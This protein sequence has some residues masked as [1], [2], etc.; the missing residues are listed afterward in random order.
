MDKASDNG[1][2]GAVPRKHRNK[3]TDQSLLP[4][5]GKN[6]LKVSDAIKKSVIEQVQS[7]KT[8]SE[9]SKE[10]SIPESTIRS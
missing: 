3:S 2:A 9:V 8:A 4:A 6:Y 1:K 5:R 10:S 7:G